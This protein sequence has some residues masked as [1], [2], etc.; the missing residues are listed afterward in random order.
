MALDDLAANGAEGR[1]F[2]WQDRLGSTEGSTASGDGVILKD[3]YP[4][5]GEGGAGL[6]G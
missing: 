5:H 6:V 1:S 4:K 3:S 2:I